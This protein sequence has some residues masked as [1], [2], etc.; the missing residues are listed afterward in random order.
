MDESKEEEAIDDTTL[1]HNASSYQ[2]VYS[3]YPQH[4]SHIKSALPTPTRKIYNMVLL[5]YSKEAGSMHIA[6]Q[7]EDVVWSMIVHGLQKMQRQLQQAQPLCDD[8]FAGRKVKIIA[9]DT[10]NEM[11]LIPLRSRTVF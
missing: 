4:L 6:Q 9:D 1:S 10:K 3:N 5:S 11:I 2:G 7:A 8:D